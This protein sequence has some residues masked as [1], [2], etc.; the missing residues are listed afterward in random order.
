MFKRTIAGRRTARNQQAGVR[1]CE[2]TA[3]HGEL[4]EGFFELDPD[5]VERPVYRL[6]WKTE[7]PLS[8]DQRGRAEFI[9]YLIAV[10]RLT[11]NVL[12]DES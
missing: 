8:D 5:S 3:G 11:D 10:G 6:R 12:A 7:D 9:R 1:T 4:R 2:T